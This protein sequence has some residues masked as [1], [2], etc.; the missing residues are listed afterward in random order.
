MY[1][2]RNAVKP[3]AITLVIEDAA[4]AAVNISSLSANAFDYYMSTNLLMPMGAKD[5]NGSGGGANLNV[6]A[7]AQQGDPREQLHRTQSSRWIPRPSF[8][9]IEGAIIDD[10][11][12]DMRICI[13]MANGRGGTAASSSTTSPELFIQVSS[14]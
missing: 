13:G 6:Q 10:A 14:L 12:S 8:V 4:R 7:P 3:D 1:M 2:V 11:A 5:A 9:Q